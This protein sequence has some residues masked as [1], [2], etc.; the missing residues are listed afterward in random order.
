M[1]FRFTIRDL[2]WL[3]A[4]VALGFGWWLDRSKL[5]AELSAFKQEMQIER[6]EMANYIDFGRP[7]DVNAMLETI[8]K[9]YQVEK[10]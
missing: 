4:L 5:S 8:R 10:K 7:A 6:N 3:T 9:K 2:L 1:R